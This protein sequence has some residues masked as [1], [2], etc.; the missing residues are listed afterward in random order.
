MDE[1]CADEDANVFLSDWDRQ[2]A[3]MICIDSDLF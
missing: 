3:W 2:E 1:H